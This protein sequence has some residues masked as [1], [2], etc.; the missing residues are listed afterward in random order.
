MTHKGK[1]Q[2]IGRLNCKK[3]N[4][5]DIFLAFVCMCTAKQIEKK[6]KWDRDTLFENE[7]NTIVHLPLNSYYDY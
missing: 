3:Q 5:R 1:A 6:I 2:Q 4:K 7:G